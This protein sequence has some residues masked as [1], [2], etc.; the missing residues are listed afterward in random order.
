MLK[1]QLRDA[2]LI[3]ILNKNLSGWPRTKA[4]ALG[5]ELAG[6]IQSV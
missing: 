6:Y 5:S 3:F 1:N 2:G 4:Q